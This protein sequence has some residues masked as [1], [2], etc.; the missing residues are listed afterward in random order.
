MQFEIIYIGISHSFYT[1]AHLYHE[2][3][4]KLG[5][6]A[7]AHFINWLIDRLVINGT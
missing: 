6:L 1:P 2:V 5:N 7:E 4:E 3:S